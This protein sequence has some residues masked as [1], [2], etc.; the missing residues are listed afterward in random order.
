MDLKRPHLVESLLK[1]L[2]WKQRIIAR[3]LSNDLISGKSYAFWGILFAKQ[4]SR[5]VR[6]VKFVYHF[7]TSWCFVICK[8]PSLL[9]IVM[10]ILLASPLE[11]LPLLNVC[12]EKSK[13]RE[14]LGIEFIILRSLLSMY[15]L[16][17]ALE[18]G[19]V[20][21]L[22]CWSCC[23]ELALHRLANLN[24]CCEAFKVRALYLRVADTTF[25]TFATALFDCNGTNRKTADEAMQ[26][27][28]FSTH[29]ILAIWHSVV[30]TFHKPIAF[31]G[32]LYWYPL[33]LLSWNW[34]EWSV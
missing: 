20:A 5:F 10:K 2:I 1:L 29:H 3:K 11:R 17:V 6:I 22:S 24:S 25:A 32:N 19:K 34:V 26:R 14:S 7:F 9:Y 28:L 31:Y 4:T 30:S 18:R 23:W 13:N 33:L 8:M 12:R 16:F 27:V 21:N 15:C